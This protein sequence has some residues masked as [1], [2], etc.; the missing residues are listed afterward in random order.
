MRLVYKGDGAS[1]AKAGTVMRDVSGDPVPFC[2]PG[3]P[4]ECA[5]EDAKA[6]MAEHPGDFQVVVVPGESP[7]KAV[8]KAPAV[9]KP[10][11]KAKAKPKAKAKAKK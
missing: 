10:K 11:A 3:T 2:V 7:A 4:F 1:F 6:L 5:D 8:V 9:R